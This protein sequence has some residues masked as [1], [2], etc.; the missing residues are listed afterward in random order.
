VPPVGQ[1]ARS[2]TGR[3]L[4]ATDDLRDPRFQRTVIFMVR[5]DGTGAMGL[6]VNR[7]LR[8]V[9][10]ADLLAQLGLAAE[11]AGGTIRVHYG[12][13]VEPRRGFVL[14]TTDWVSPESRVIQ[15]NVALSV[16]PAVVEAIAG[17]AGPGRFLFALGY[18]GWGP[19]QLEGEIERGA[20]ISVVGDEA[21]V[22]DGNAGR[23]WERAMARRPI[24]L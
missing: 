16:G 15:R 21:L 8:D 2:L 12:G 24:A 6:V 3:L 18:A 19:G 14:H 9:A 22:F 23:K 5:H 7:P 1:A 11:G 4:V 13:P 17:G 10:L 20:W